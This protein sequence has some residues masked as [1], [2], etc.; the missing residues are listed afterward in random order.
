MFKAF[1]SYPASEAELASVASKRTPEIL[2]TQP[3]PPL[4][5][6]RRS[7]TRSFSRSVSDLDQ[8][9][10]IE[11]LSREN[12]ALQQ[13]LQQILTQLKNMQKDRDESSIVIREKE[14]AA[15]DL[16]V[17]VNNLEREKVEYLATIQQLRARLDQMTSG[18]SSLKSYQDPTS[19]MK[20]STGIGVEKGRHLSIIPADEDS[21]FELEE[22]RKILAKLSAELVTYQVKET[23]SSKK[24]PSTSK[25][26]K[27]VA[28]S[29]FLGSKFLAKLPPWLSNV[30]YLSPLVLAYEVC[31]PSPLFFRWTSQCFH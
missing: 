16:D 19:S 25:Q 7:S 21:K 20:A 22:L 31:K 12:G 26:P 11:V 9:A 8:K 13:R 1:G 5:L 3:S 10:R 24:M 30:Q 17:K 18:S 28:T 29:A 23:T 2:V 27:S 4:S 6:S 15:R 14:T